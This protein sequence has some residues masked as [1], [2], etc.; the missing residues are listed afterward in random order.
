[1]PLEIGSVAPI[2]DLPT[3]GGGTLSL[4]SLKGKKVIL[5]FYPKDMTPGCTKES[6]GF[7]DLSDEFK[8]ANTVIVGVSKDSVKQHDKFKTKYAKFKK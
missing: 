3:D 2:F 8:L 6:E 1:M 5:F 4:T 7:R